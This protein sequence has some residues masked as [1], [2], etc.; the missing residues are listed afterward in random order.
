MTLA[1]FFAAQIVSDE[2]IARR[3]AEA[4]VVRKAGER[5]DDSLLSDGGLLLLVTDVDRVKYGFGAHARLETALF[6]VS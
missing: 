1:N 5:G 3:A 6:A 2:A 4:V